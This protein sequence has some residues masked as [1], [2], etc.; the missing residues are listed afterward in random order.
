MKTHS[1][2]QRISE[3]L[4]EGRGVGDWQNKL[5][6]FRGTNFYLYDK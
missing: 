3:W 6:E 1:Q 4:P 2:I 5:R